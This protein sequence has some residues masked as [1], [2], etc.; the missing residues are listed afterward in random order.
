LKIAHGIFQGLSLYRALFHVELSTLTLKGKVLDLGGK[1]A[2]A[3]YYAHIDG[4]SNCEIVVTDLEPKLG[5]IALDVERAFP[6]DDGEFD[7]V[8][9]FNL[10]EHVYRYQGAPSEVYRILKPGGSVVICVPFLHEFHADPHDY[11][12]FTAPALRLIWE[13]CGLKCTRMSALGEGLLTYALTKTASL[14]LPRTAYRI[15]APVLYMLVMPI[16]RIV[17]LRPKLDGLTMPARFP[18]GYY[19]IFEKPR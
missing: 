6:L 15:I 9:A 19:A 7:F 3:S 10:F 5:V 13:Q 11:F 18:L 12:R 17:S 1:S 2:N 14:V 8:L 16:D 4:S